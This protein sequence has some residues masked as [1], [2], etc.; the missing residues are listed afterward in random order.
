MALSSVRLDGFEADADGAC[1]DIDECLAGDACGANEDCVNSDGAFEC[2]CSAGYGNTEE[3][4]A[5]VDLNECELGTY[6]CDMNATCENTEG[7]YSCTCNDGYDG[8]GKTC[9]DIDE[10]ALETD[11]CGDYTT[12]ANGGNSYLCQGGSCGDDACLAAV[13]AMDSFCN[14]FWDSYCAD[15][16]AGGET[17]GGDSCAGQVDACAE[18]TKYTC[19]C[20]EGYGPDD[21]GL[22]CSDI[23]ECATETDMCAQNCANTAGG[24][25][26]SCDAGYT[27]ADDAM[28]C[29]DIDECANGEN[30]CANQCTNTP[31]GYECGCPAGYVLAAD[32]AGCDDID[33][34]ADNNGGCAQNCVNNDGSFE[35]TCDA[36]YALNADGSTC[37]DIDECADKNGGCAQTCTNSI[38]SFTCSCDKGYTLNADGLGCD[39]ID[40]CKGINNCSPNATCTNL[41]GSFSCTCNPGYSGDGVTCEQDAPQVCSAK[42]YAADVGADTLLSC[43][44]GNDGFNFLCNYA[45]YGKFTGNAPQG[46]FNSGSPCWAVGEADG[47]INKL[48]PSC[49]SGCTHYEYVEC[50][51]PCGVDISQGGKMVFGHHGACEGWNGCGSAEGCAD[52][53]CQYYGHGQALSWDVVTHSLKGGCTPAQQWN[54]FGEGYPNGIDLSWNAADQCS[55]CPLNGVA[56]VVCEEQNNGGGGPKK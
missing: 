4:P 55:S 7:N 26:C 14:S 19:D 36:G 56:N 25:D 29:D 51:K 23:D 46:D 40:E 35:C 21:G 16:A 10:C 13:A 33:E 37:D 3:D 20:D 30:E 50:E 49:G 42:V 47:H 48:Y 32:G 5:C 1:V 38:G 9:T 12:C 8:D 28:G 44:G 52:K 41:G 53:A 6:E 39:D 34:C 27:L 11:E 24:Y 54:L 18:F 45:G 43:I 22:T 15:C 17:W 2:V 31:G